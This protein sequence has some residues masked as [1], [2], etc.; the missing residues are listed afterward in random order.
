MPSADQNPVKSTHSKMPW[1]MWVVLIAG[2][3]GTALSAVRPPNH[4]FTPD[5]RCNFVPS[6]RESG[7][8]GRFIVTFVPCHHRPGHPGEFVGERN[9]CDLSGSSG[10]QSS[11]PGPMT[12]TMDF[13]I[14]DHSERTGRKQA[15]QIA[16]ALFADTAQLVLATARVLLRYRAQPRP[17][18]LVPIG[19]PWDQ[20][21]WRPEPL[22]AP[23]RR[24]VSHPAACS[25]RLIDATLR[26]VGRTPGFG[27]SVRA[28]DCREQQDK[29]EP[30]RGAD[31]RLY[32][33]RLPAV[34]RRP[35]ARQE[36]RSRTR[37]DR[38]GSN[39]SR[40]SASG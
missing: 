24:P 36:R 30:P 8:S 26:C 13:G 2:S 3:T 28:V 23:D 17:R 1:P 29:H 5:I 16:I 10:Q 14:A 32:R 22:P 11:E 21:C 38:R 33:Q 31:S 7:K 9:G 6:R 34:A 12:S 20:Q 35:C 39:L 19:K 40:R 15:A 18:S 25:S 27:P 37:Q 4:Y